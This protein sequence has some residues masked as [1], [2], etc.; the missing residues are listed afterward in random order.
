MFYIC[1]FAEYNVLSTLQ[2]NNLNNSNSS[3]N[4]NYLNRRI[5]DDNLVTQRE[6]VEHQKPNLPGHKRS[7]SYGAGVFLDDHGSSDHTSVNGPNYQVENEEEAESSVKHL[8]RSFNAY[9]VLEERHYPGQPDIKNSESIALF[10]EHRQLSVKLLRTT[11]EI[12]RLESYLKD[13][14][15]WNDDP[16]RDNAAIYMR[17]V[18]ENRNLKKLTAS[19]I[20]QLSTPR[21]SRSNS[22]SGQQPNIRE[23]EVG[24]GW[25]L[26]DQPAFGA[27]R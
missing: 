23:M 16:N 18:D 26:V 4:S 14:Q 15:T 11:F 24:N 1:L 5:S 7:S 20:D 21:Q 22:S 3:N 8:L 19:F 2:N 17:F 13:L 6:V 27:P 25:T 9:L 12:A 10:E